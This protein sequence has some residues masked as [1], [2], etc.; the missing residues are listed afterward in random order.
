MDIGDVLH[1]ES[2][3]VDMYTDVRDAMNIGEACEAR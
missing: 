2:S 1:M 3:P